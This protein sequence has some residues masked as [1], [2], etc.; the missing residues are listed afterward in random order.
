[1]VCTV[2][3]LVVVLVDVQETLRKFVVLF[4]GILSTSFEQVNRSRY[5]NT[6]K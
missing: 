2:R 6:M 1:M 3:T 5:K 4:G